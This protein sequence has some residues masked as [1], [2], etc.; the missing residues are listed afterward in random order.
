MVRNTFEF[1][2]VISSVFN[3]ERDFYPEKYFSASTHLQPVTFPGCS[4]LRTS[5]SVAVLRL[6]AA[7]LPSS[8][9]VAFTHLPNAHRGMNRPET[10][11]NLALTSRFFQLD[12]PRRMRS[13][14][15]ILT[16]SAFLH[17]PPF[18]SAGAGLVRSG[19]DQVRHTVS[20][21]VRQPLDFVWLG[22]LGLSSLL[23]RLVRCTDR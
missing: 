18:L 4:A 21:S 15:G 10:L 5:L 13:S 6:S 8:A 23:T 20:Y 3:H 7:S 16:K 22:Q 9:T 1:L 11:I 14:G 19:P 2:E 12:M 17:P